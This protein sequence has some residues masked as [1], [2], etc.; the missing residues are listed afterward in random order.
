MP[1]DRS[2]EAAQ[3]RQTGL[4]ARRHH[5]RVLRAMGQEDWCAPVGVVAL[6]LGAVQQRQVAG[7]A[8]QTG[9]PRRMPQARHERHRAALREAHQHDAL[10]RDA[11]LAL[12]AR[13]QLLNEHARLSQAVGVLA[14]A[15]VA[16]ADVVPG[17]H[18]HAVVDRHRDHRRARQHEAQA[19]VRQHGAQIERLADRHEVVAVGAQAVQHEDAEAR[20]LL[21]LQ[22]DGLEAHGQCSSVGSVGYRANASGVARRSGVPCIV[23]ATRRRADVMT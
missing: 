19:A 3:L 20:R 18:R 11:V 13:D 9:E 17:A 1:L 22:F 10:R 21:G 2:A 5:H 8:D 12:L 15:Q 6:G 14:L 4:G 23:A 16:V 7:Q